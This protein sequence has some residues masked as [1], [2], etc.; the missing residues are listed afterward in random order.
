MCEDV[1]IKAIILYSHLKTNKARND[2]SQTE[3]KF[4]L[5]LIATDFVFQGKQFVKI[6]VFLQDASYVPC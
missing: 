6:A 1:T 4:T 2:N 5:T 3:V